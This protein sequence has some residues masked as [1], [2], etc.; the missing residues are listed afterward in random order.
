LAKL[1]YIR[2]DVG[3][4]LPEGPNVLG[5]P[6]GQSLKLVLNSAEAIPRDHKLVTN[7]LQVLVNALELIGEGQE[8]GI[9]TWVDDGNRGATVKESCSCGC[10]RRWGTIGVNR[11]QGDASIR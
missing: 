11:G 7:E 2:L 1:A 10:M 3:D 8:E 5:D 9:I 6:M 4:L